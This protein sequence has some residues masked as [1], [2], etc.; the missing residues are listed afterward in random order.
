MGQL[1]QISL[2]NGYKM[3]PIYISLHLLYLLLNNLYSE[4]QHIIEH[5][6]LDYVAHPTVRSAMQVYSLLHLGNYYKILIM[7]EKDSR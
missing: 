2:K 5:L 7:Y 6:S 1:R 4:Y 3:K